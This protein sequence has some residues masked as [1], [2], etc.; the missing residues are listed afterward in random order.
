MIPPSYKT[1]REIIKVGSGY[2]RAIIENSIP[3]VVNLSGIGVHLVD[4]P[5]PARANFHNE[6]EFNLIQ[7]TNVLHLRPGLFYSNFYGAADMIR[8]QHIIGNNFGG[9][10]ILALSHSHDIA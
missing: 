10:I 4:G 7:G 9:N 1:A 8:Q 3:Y 2:V 5:G 6:K